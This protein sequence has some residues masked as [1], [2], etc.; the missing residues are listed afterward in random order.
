MYVDIVDIKKQR[1]AQ[2]MQS[3]ISNCPCV[4]VFY[5]HIIIIIIIAIMMQ[6]SSAIVLYL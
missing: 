1:Y 2:L 4:K 3:K 5:I 6:C